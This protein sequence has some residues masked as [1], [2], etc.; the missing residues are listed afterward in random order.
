MEN[1]HI[2]VAQWWT[3]TLGSLGVG[4]KPGELIVGGFGDTVHRK[5]PRDGHFVFVQTFRPS[6]TSNSKHTI[7][8]EHT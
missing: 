1:G 7:R 4:S 6:P 2:I 3:A 8:E 5:L